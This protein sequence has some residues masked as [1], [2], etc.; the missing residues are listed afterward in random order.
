MN[1]NLKFLNFFPNIKTHSLKNFVIIFLLSFAFATSTL[2]TNVINISLSKVSFLI[3]SVMAVSNFPKV[4][5][6]EKIGIFIRL[7]IIF[8]CIVIFSTFFNGDII[9]S[10][11]ALRWVAAFFLSLSISALLQG[12]GISRSLRYKIMINSCIAA[13]GIFIAYTLIF[14]NYLPSLIDFIFYNK[15]IS[16]RASSLAS[17]P[18]ILGMFGSLLVS[19]IYVKNI[20][21][22]NLFNLIL[23]ISSVIIFISGS[24]FNALIFLLI[25]VSTFFIYKNF[26]LSSLT[27][28]LL[29]I[30]SFLFLIHHQI[31]KLFFQ[32]YTF[33]SFNDRVTI[34]N[35]IYHHSI[36]SNDK[37]MHYMFGWGPDD[38]EKIISYGQAH[39]W[40]FDFFL[41]VGFLGLL[42]FIFIITFFYLAQKGK[43]INFSL[44][45][46][47]LLISNLMSGS[48]GASSI[49][50]LI[51]IF[52]F[53][54]NVKKNS[55]KFKR[56]HE[57]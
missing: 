16:P 6:I 14:E 13:G 40:I 7:A 17:G 57:A 19:M 49:S 50:Y 46:S 51:I 55:R 35:K 22:V 52:A 28:F 8:I 12:Y 54:F 42:S 37:F 53:S 2:Y 30:L 1:S 9:F 32:D 27:I 38:V 11:F 26:L 36:N 24:K 34:I 31:Y 48:F 47:I 18:N 56:Y 10:K 39:N 45:L 3:L 15:E 25:L 5:Q 29:F 4:L 23:I 44:P 20:K 43:K 21:N 33:D 41:R